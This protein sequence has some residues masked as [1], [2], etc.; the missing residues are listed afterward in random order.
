[1]MLRRNNQAPNHRLINHGGRQNAVEAL[2]HDGAN[3]LTYIEDCYH[4]QV[5]LFTNPWLERNNPASWMSP[6]PLA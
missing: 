6:I 2:T 5:H 4:V 3:L 1:M